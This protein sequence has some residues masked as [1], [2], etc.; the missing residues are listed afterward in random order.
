MKAFAERDFALAAPDDKGLSYR[1][2][3]EG[4]RERTQRPERLAE[5]ERELTLP[6]FPAAL[7]YL[8]SAFNRLRRRKGGNGFAPSPLEWSDIDAFVRHSG[9]RLAPWEI[10]LIEDLDD[11]WLAERGRSSA[12]AALP[13]RDHA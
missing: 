9:A 4:M 6:P 1:E 3:L 7:A 11:L 5:I 8:W 12:A 13:P 10:A 2:A